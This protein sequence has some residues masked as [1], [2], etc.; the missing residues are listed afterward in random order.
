M[1]ARLNSPERITQFVAE[2]KSLEKKHGFEID[3]HGE[4]VSYIR[5]LWT[6]N[7]HSLIVAKLFNDSDLEIL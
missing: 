7:N 6:A 1:K 5:D 2:L 4:F 3:H